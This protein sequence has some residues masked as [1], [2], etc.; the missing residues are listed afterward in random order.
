MEAKKYT[1]VDEYHKQF[2]GVVRIALD[3]L[4]TTIK[5]AAPH[6]AEVISYNMPAF[7]QGSVLVYYAANKEHIGFYPTSSP[8]V[9][10]KDELKNYKTSKGAIQF[11]LDK[12]IPKT[13]VKKIVKFRLNEVNQ[14]T[15]AQKLNSYIPL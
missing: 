14:K 7:R 5:K 11:P 8:I 3:D 4:R 9:V 12:P 1:T 15:K 2:S 13:L 6:A 10:F